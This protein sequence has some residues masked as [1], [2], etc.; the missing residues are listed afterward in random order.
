LWSTIS[1]SLVVVLAATTLVVAV[2]PVVTVAPSVANLL[3]VAH[4]PKQN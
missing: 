3:V 2:E 4:Q 1:S